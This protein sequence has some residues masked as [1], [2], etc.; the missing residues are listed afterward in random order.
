MG[1]GS[2][3][4][5]GVVVV[6]DIRRGRVI[7]DDRLIDIFGGLTDHMY[8]P[9]TILG[10]GWRCEPR[11]MQVWKRAT[12]N[13]VW[14]VNDVNSRHTSLVR[15]LLRIIINATMKNGREKTQ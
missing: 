3:S 14:G 12:S 8:W 9:P 11:F 2:R 4:G 13:P 1:A 5:E 7:A 6:L 15:S 10:P